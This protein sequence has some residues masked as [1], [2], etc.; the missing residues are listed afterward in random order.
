VREVL[1]APS[2]AAKKRAREQRDKAF[3][4]LKAAFEEA[5]SG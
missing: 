5:N 1:K 4:V 3:A 2:E